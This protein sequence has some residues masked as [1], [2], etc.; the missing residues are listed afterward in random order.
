MKRVLFSGMIAVLAL[1]GSGCKEDDS[2]TTPTAGEG[3]INATVVDALT[4]TPVQG[5]T[6]LAGSTTTSSDADG[7]FVL[8]FTVDSLATVTMVLSKSG[9]RDTSIVT[10][11]RSGD[12]QT[13]QIRLQSSK[14]VGGGSGLAQTIAFLGATPEEISVYGVGGT[15]TTILAYEVRD[16][17][18]LSI[19]AAHAVNLS[20]SIVNGPQGGEYVSPA[21]VTTNA[22]GQAYTTVNAGTRSGVAQVVATA[23][24]GARTITTSPVRV[25]IN[26]GFPVQSHF[27]IAATHYNFAAL[28][29]VNRQLEISVLVGDMYSNPVAPKTAVYFRSSAGVVQPSVFTDANGQGGVTLFSGNPYPFAPFGA[30]SPLDTAYHHVVAKTVGQNG[31]TVTDSI[32]VLW[33]GRSLIRNVNPAGFTIANGGSQLFTFSAC[34]RFHHPLS[35]GTVITVLALVPP[36]PDPNSPV[37]QAQLSF[38]VNGRITM[39]D[40]IFRGPGTTDFSFQLSDGSV[41][42]DQPTTVTITIEVEGPNGQA[43]HTFSGTMN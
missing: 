22:G 28:D 4:G 35:P 15:E 37:N 7:K 3:V 31:V 20:F 2:S 19:D 1:A 32:L 23:T 40:A 26:G 13:V 8:R 39:E 6:V 24:V 12:V 5:V 42:V 29:W 14:P 25:T 9:Y 43:I 38:G 27:T 17:L 11:L 21:V 36:P 10:Q 34:D 33:S 41:N 18:G 16:S 30:P